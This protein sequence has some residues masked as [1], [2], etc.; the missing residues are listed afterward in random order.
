MMKSMRFFWLIPILVGLVILF[1]NIHA[2]KI[3]Q[4]YEGGMDIEISYPDKI[5]VGR[6]LYQF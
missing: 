5:V 1:P 2:K 3:T 4:N 6:E